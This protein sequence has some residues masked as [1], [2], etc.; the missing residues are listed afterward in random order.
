MSKDTNTTT[1]SIDEFDVDAWIDGAS[2]AVEEITVTNDLT[3]AVEAAQAMEDLR[4][5]V[6]AADREKADGTPVKGRRLAQ[7]STDDVQ[8]AR[9]RVEELQARNPRSW[10]TIRVS[11]L[12]EDTRAGI[13]DAGQKGRDFTVHAMAACATIRPHGAPAEQ[14]RKITADQWRKVIESIAGQFVEVDN[15]LAKVTLGAVVTPDFWG[16]SSP[17]DP[18]S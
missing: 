8:A 12:P 14:G 11:T 4:D 7:A 2:A 9:A 16:A 15:A 17:A 10:V 3:L 5:A 6:D 18:T 1:P 13:A